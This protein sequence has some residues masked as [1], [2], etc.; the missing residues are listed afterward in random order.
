MASPTGGLPPVGGMTASES[1]SPPLATATSAT[2]AAITSSDDTNDLAAGGE[3]AHPFLLDDS[4]ANTVPLYN[5]YALHQRVDLIW[6]LHQD[7][8]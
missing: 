4:D 8:D 7:A 3:P 6:D 1:V 5:D 2:V